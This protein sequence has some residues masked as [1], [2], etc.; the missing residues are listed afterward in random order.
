MLI[1]GLTDSHFLLN[2]KLWDGGILGRALSTEDLPTCPAMMLQR[3]GD[4]S[5]ASTRSFTIRHHHSVT[6]GTSPPAA[7]EHCPAPAPPSRLKESC[8][9]LGTAQDQGTWRGRSS[10]HLPRHNPKL[11]TTSVAL[12]SIHPVWSLFGIRRIRPRRARASRRAPPQSSSGA[13]QGALQNGD[14]GSIRSSTG[15]TDPHIIPSH[16]PRNWNASGSSDAGSHQ[17][18][19]DETSSLSWSLSPLSGSSVQQPRT[20]SMAPGALCPQPGL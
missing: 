13:N 15:I 8:K 7:R 3:M 17:A 1:A 9:S 5:V 6:P 16:V 2:P 18:G 4:I 19:Q 12:L 10:T 14:T 11:H 20:A